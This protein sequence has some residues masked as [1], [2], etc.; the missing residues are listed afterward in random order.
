[1][2][3]VIAKFW[4][5]PENQKEFFEIAH[6][7]GVKSNEEAGVKLYELHADTTDPERFAT[8]EVYREQAIHAAHAESA[9]V[10]DLFPKMCALC[11]EEP[12]IEFYQQI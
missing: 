11:V 6:K 4:V 10:K 2:Y 8:I 12:V 7:L 9:H 3:T 5:K 1:M